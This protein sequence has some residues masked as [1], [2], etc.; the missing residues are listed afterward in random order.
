MEEG[1]SRPS[2]WYQLWSVLTRRG[3]T[4][5]EELN[6]LLE[7]AKGNQV[8]AQDTFELINKTLDFS[9]LEVRDAMV[10]YSH[11]KV[12]HLTDSIE[13]IIEFA[14]RTSHSRF[15]VV[16]NHE[17]DEIVGILHIKDL[18][19]FFFQHEQFNIRDLLREAMYVPESKH[20][21][22]LLS[23]FREQRS[24]LAIV[25]D[26]YG[27]VSGLVT[28]EDVIEQIFGQISDEF[29]PEAKDT[30]V[31]LSANSYQVLATTEIEAFNEY[32]G[33][34]L[35]EEEVDTIGGLVLSLFGHMP[36]RGE[37]I[38]KDGFRFQVARM[39]KRRILLLKVTR[40]NDSTQQ[41]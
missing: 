1:S 33:S 21:S 30:I 25:V 40:I 36:L 14:L 3:P 34:H 19:H 39:E 12:I 9:T 27:G 31:P 16:E 18:L 15:P 13:K 35:A 7:K 23:K 20:L 2:I 28:L 5:R 8:I 32:F 41:N 24:H 22:A 17:K 26:E 4:T 11:M 38:D 6:S 10:T 29:D 37:W